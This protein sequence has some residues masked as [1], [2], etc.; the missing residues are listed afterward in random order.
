M[1]D[2]LQVLNPLDGKTPG[3]ANLAGLGGTY[4]PVNVPRP[5]P[6]TSLEEL[7]AGLGQLNAGLQGAFAQ[8]L[9]ERDEQAEAEGE[10]AFLENQM[11]FAQMVREGRIEPGQNPHFRRGVTGAHLRALSER[12]GSELRMAHASSEVANSDDPAVLNQFISEFHQNFMREN[13][14]DAFDDA[15]VAEF[16]A[17]RA[18]EQMVQMQSAH[19]EMRIEK[20]REEAVEA[21]GVEVNSIIDPFIDPNQDGFLTDQDVTDIGARLAGIV[22]PNNRGSNVFNGLPQREAND[23]LV[24]AVVLRAKETNNIALLDVLSSI[25]TGSGSLGSITRY[26]D[27]ITSAQI[28]IGRE[29][30]ARESHQATMDERARRDRE[31]AFYTEGLQMLTEGVDSEELFTRLGAMTQS[32]PA[33]AAAAERIRQVWVARMNE[34]YNV[35]ED[36]QTIAELYDAVLENPEDAPRLI[37]TASSNREISGNT[38]ANLTRFSQIN[39]EQVGVFHSDRYAQAERDIARVIAGDTDI[40]PEEEAVQIIAARNMMRDDVATWIEENTRD[41]VMPRS[42]PHSVMQGFLADALE[43]H[44]VLRENIAILRGSNTMNDTT[45]VPPPDEQSPLFKGNPFADPS[46]WTPTDRGPGTL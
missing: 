9:E 10:R 36:P 18:T 23:A 19:S 7:A 43:A 45:F 1:T 28:A 29:V 2:R 6:G 40:F 13:G 25:P 12:F 39:R 38:A 17:E 44:G 22:D 31:R 32:G 15:E 24:D 4:Q 14:F 26:R 5:N 46:M 27:E 41:G 21:I 34:Q 37:I 30:R 33:G 11:G 42:I 16:Y 35:R 8:E 3:R 20:L